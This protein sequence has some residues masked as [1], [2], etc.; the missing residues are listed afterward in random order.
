MKTL[1][2]AYTAHV[3]AITRSIAEM[4]ADVIVEDNEA[5]QNTPCEAV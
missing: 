1:G 3:S 4:S 5:A 2:R